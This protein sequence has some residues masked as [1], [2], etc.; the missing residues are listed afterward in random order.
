MDTIKI[1]MQNNKEFETQVESYNATG[2]AKEIKESEESIVSIGDLVIN[3][4]HI[5]CI[6]KVSNQ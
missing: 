2:L 4:F 6:H 5:E 1:I 3:K